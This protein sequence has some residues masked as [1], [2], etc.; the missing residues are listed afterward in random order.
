MERRRTYLEIDTGR[1]RAYSGIV[2]AVFVLCAGL[3]A[4]AN[5]VTDP[6]G[7][8]NA[9]RLPHVNANKPGQHGQDRM[10]KADALRSQHPD[11]LLL[12]TSRTQ[13]GMDPNNPDLARFGQHPYNAGLLGSGP[14]L[15]LRY[16]QHA[17]ANAHVR[18]VVLGLDPLMFDESTNEAGQGFAEERLDV[19]PDGERNML[20][21]WSHDVPSTLLSTDAVK[22][23]LRTV[24]RQNSIV[25]DLLD[26]GLR[27]PTV[28]QEHSDQNHGTRGNF[29]ATERDYMAMFGRYWVYDESGH[30]KKLEA[31]ASLLDFA[32][33]N[34][35]A[36][37]LYVSPSH[38]R[39]NEVIRVAGKQ[40]QVD[41]WK[42]A[43]VLLLAEDHQRH[44]A[45]DAVTLMDFSDANPY[46]SERLP[47]ANAPTAS[48]R[49]YW[50]TSHFKTSLGDMVLKRVLT[51]RGPKLFG[52]ALTRD[53]IEQQLNASRQRQRQYENSHPADVQEIEQLGDSLAR[54]CVAEKDCN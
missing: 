51:G 13:F 7:V 41:A 47:A 34:G 52:R 27:N 21:A 5:Y 19:T 48:M 39:M 12:G 26:N 24:L 20:P 38:A 8:Y 3:T 15:A 31:L 33:A 32:H 30:S 49:W 53:N 35:T 6:Y 40:D 36:V 28:L 54:G 1:N 25:T 11:V 50:E 4:A 37:R 17:E 16:L 45:D 46:T 44:P 22:M 18:L 23:S 43:L 10:V 29:V 42:R 14:Y 2:L 9:P